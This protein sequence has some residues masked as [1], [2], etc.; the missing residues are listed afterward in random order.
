MGRVR[1][2]YQAVIMVTGAIE[3]ILLA[4]K[5]G[6]SRISTARAEADRSIQQAHRDA[7]VYVQ[8]R[9]EEAEKRVSEMITRSLG[10]R[11]ET[12]RR[13]HESAFRDRDQIRI[14]GTERIP[15]AVQ[16]ALDLVTGGQ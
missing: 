10:E 15:D 11:E 8:T 6:E 14:S 12:V 4:E 2:L 1:S 3:R 7:G 9:R 13:I 16:A 5:E